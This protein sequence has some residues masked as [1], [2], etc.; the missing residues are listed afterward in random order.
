[1]VGPRL[2]GYP[3][4]SVRVP[5]LFQARQVQN[6][7]KISLETH[8]QCSNCGSAQIR[9]SHLLNLQVPVREERD[10]LVLF[11]FLFYAQISAASFTPQ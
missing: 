3:V 5:V 6:L 7:Y 2:H 8:L 4:G 1:M 10:S 11:H 9:S